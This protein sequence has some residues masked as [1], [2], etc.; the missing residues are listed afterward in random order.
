VIGLDTNVLVRYAAQDDA[1]QSALVEELF[2]PLTIESPGFVSTVAL[3][4]SVWVLRRVFQVDGESIARFVTHLLSARELVVE[5]PEAVRN[6]IDSTGGS[7]EFNDALLA[8]VGITGGCD[9]TV[10]FDK[11][12]ASLP[13]MRLLTT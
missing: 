8:Q 6:A 5:H 10:T 13:G 3:V 2:G 12:A 4:E 7:P 9:Y 11:R 1:Q